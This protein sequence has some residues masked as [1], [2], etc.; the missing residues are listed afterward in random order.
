MNK[1]GENLNFIKNRWNHHNSEKIIFQKL[2]SQNDHKK[3]DFF[4]LK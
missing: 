4:N 2:K 3:N 1:L